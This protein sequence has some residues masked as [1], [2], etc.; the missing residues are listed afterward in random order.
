MLRVPTQEELDYINEN[1]ARETLSADSIYLMDDVVIANDYMLSCWNYYLSTDSLRNFVED[2]KHGIPLQDN[3]G[4]Q[5]DRAMVPVG[6]W[7]L[8]AL[9]EAEGNMPAGALAGKRTNC[10]AVLYMPKG[11]TIAGLNTDEVVK[12]YKFGTLDDVSVGQNWKNAFFRCNLCGKSILDSDCPH[13]PGWEYEG[14]RATFTVENSH[15]GE[16]SFAW[17]GGLPGLL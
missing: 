12:A 8:G 14:V 1:F 11:L 3:H 9:V 5:E 13:I 16:V 4:E 7:M 10:T 2:L 6:K 15:L 17:A